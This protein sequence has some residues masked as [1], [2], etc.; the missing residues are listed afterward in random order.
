LSV[1]IRVGKKYTIV[2]P[3]EVRKR[4]G[5]S[6]GSLLLARVV[7]NKIVLEPLPD[8]PFKVLD[9]L[10]TEPYSEGVDEKRAEK[11]LLENASR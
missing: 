4:I 2:I 5:L 7:G 3:K 9:Q 11:W 6:E 10:I 8:D 1:I